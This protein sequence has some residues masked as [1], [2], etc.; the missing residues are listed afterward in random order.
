M[1]IGV[2]KKGHKYL[3]PPLEGIHVILLK[4]SKRLEP[5]ANGNQEVKNCRIISYVYIYVNVDVVFLTKKLKRKKKMAYLMFVLQYFLFF[6]M[7]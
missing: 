4:E 2:V 3:F 7:L 1:N 6:L 5:I